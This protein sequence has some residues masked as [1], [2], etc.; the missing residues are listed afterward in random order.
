MGVTV[1]PL[2]QRLAARRRACGRRPASRPPRGRRR[3]AR[4][5][6]CGSS[7]P[8]RARP[9]DPGRP[10]R[11]RC[12]RCASR[13]RRSRRRAGRPPRT[14]PRS[15]RS[16]R[17]RGSTRENKPGTPSRPIA[18]TASMFAR[19]TRVHRERVRLRAAEHHDARHEVGPAAG[20]HLGEAAAAAVADDRRTPALALDQPLEAVL[21]PLDAWRPSRRRCERMPARLGWWPVPLSQRAITPERGVA[22][23]EARDQ[24][25]GLAA[26]VGHAPAA[27]APGP[28]P[29]PPA[30][31][32]SGIRAREV[33]SGVAGASC[34]PTPGRPDYLPARVG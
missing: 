23:H 22:G 26:A 16:S 28:G 6:R 19:T 11:T 17:R 9:P 14:A 15:S 12:R 33:G 1:A 34:A 13:P 20:Q 10:S 5:C 29:A 2:L 7:A 27:E 24:Q 21:E 31:G 32:P 4:P 3:A 18:A 8:P 25:H 30:R